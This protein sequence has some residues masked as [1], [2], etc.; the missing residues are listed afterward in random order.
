MAVK[1]KID[2]YSCKY[3]K[4]CVTVYNSGYIKMKDI[5]DFNEKLYNQIPN[6]FVYTRT[7]N[8]WYKEFVAHN[9]L[10]KMG[11]FKSHTL[12][13]DISEDE[14]LHRLVAYNIIYFFYSIYEKLTK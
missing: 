9:I 8:S 1:I 12:D 5:K 2:G 14:Q 3:C 6:D 11:L 10:F 13:L 7:K 4:R